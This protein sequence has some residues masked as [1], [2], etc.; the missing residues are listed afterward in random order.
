MSG[1]YGTPAAEQAVAVPLVVRG[2]A[3]AVL[4]AD[5]GTQLGSAI[6][7]EALEAL[8]RVT[9]M[10]I[11]LLPVRRGAEQTALAS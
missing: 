9:S 6:N 11:E 8:T 10:A 7:L 3:A 5:A 4:Y 2:K 1:R